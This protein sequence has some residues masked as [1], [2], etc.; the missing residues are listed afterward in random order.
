MSD[1]LVW[2]GHIS[3]SCAKCIPLSIDLFF[4]LDQSQRGSLFTLF[5][6]NPLMA[7]LFVS[8]LSS[9][10]RG[11]WEKCQDYL[12]K[13]NRDIAQLLTHSRSIGTAWPAPAQP[14]RGVWAFLN[15]AFF[16]F[17]T[18]QSFLQFFGDEFLRLLLTRFIFCSATMR[19]HKIFRV[20]RD[21]CAFV[22]APELSWLRWE[23]PRAEQELRKVTAAHI[24]SLQRTEAVP[25]VSPKGQSL[26]PAPSTAGTLHFSYGTL[27]SLLC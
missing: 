22:G 1:F 27:D 24:L 17:C 2:Q 21:V 20:C 12:R 6:N 4:L 19:M 7:F 11:L 5:L 26:S 13:I 10:R 9:M 14:A 25:C 18:D 3:V 15:P 8:G 23:G 16:A